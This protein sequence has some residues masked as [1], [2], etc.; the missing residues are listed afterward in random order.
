M[1]HQEHHLPLLPPLPRFLKLLGLQMLYTLAKACDTSQKSSRAVERGIVKVLELLALNTSL[2][3]VLTY[4]GVKGCSGI[5]GVASPE[6][7]PV[8][9]AAES[10]SR[11]EPAAAEAVASLVSDS[12]QCPLTMDEQ[13]EIEK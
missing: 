2:R 9:A 1:D 4:G 6:G 10:M 11:A 3:E 13:T 5:G 7:A 12:F 8:P